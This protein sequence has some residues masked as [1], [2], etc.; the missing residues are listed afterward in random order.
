M[1]LHGFTT[2]LAG[3]NESEQTYFF[4]LRQKKKKKNGNNRIKYK[5]KWVYMN[6]FVKKINDNCFVSRSNCRTYQAA[7]Q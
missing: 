6:N 1:P 7:S 5:F 4:F 3:L 2:V